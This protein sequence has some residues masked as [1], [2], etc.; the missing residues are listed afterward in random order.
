MQCRHW[1]QRDWWSSFTHALIGWLGISLTW[2]NYAAGR[3]AR[4]ETGC[5]HHHTPLAQIYATA[6]IWKYN[7]QIYAYKWL[8]HNLFNVIVIY[9][10]GHCPPAYRVYNPIWLHDPCFTCHLSFQHTSIPIFF[11]RRAPARPV[12]ACFVRICCAVVVKGQDPHTTT[13]HCKARWHFAFQTSHF[14]LHTLHST[15]HLISSELFSP[16]LSS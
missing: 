7:Q 1:Y 15:L 10:L 12:R 2:A 16:R 3:L 8:Y 6:W 9:S 4:D 13:L 5:T 11:M 14:T